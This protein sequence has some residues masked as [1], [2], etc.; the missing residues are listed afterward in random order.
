MRRYKLGETFRDPRLSALRAE[1]AAALSDAGLSNP[2]IAQA[3][4]LKY[5]N[6]E[7]ARRIVKLGR[8]YRKAQP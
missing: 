5:K 7:R 8:Q 4:G 6:R 3:L 1:Y 2:A